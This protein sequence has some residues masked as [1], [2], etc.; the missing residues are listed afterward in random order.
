[1]EET[2]RTRSA[3]ATDRNKNTIFRMPAVLRRF[4]GVGAIRGSRVTRATT[5]PI[6]P[7]EQLCAQ[8]LRL[9]STIANAK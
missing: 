5:S 6:T 3:D 8:Q 4:P 1:V 2:V 9:Y 7:D